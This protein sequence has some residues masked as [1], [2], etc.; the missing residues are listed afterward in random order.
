MKKLSV[1]LLVALCMM[2]LTTS[3]FAGAKNQGATQPLDY[4][5]VTGCDGVCDN[6]CD[7]ICDGT[8]VPNDYDY[9]YL[10]TKKGK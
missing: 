4:Y 7:G 3:V 10:G 1:M 9:R 5:L 8:C 6:V 2:L